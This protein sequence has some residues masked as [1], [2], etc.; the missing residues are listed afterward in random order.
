MT[1][2]WR[3]RKY[4]HYARTFPGDAALAYRKEGWRGVVRT[5]ADRSVR[6]CIRH[7]RL[8]VIA[9][10]LKESRE[11]SPPPGVTI[12]VARGDADWAALAAI[13]PAHQLEQFRAR[14]GPGRTCLAA[15]RDR[16]PIGY[17]WCAERVAPDILP[18]PVALPPDAAY[19]FDLYVV[20]AE[21]G[22]N[23]GSALAS[24]RMALARSR[25]CAEGWRLVAPENHASLRT[26]EKTGGSGTR[27]V[28]ELHYVKLGPR[29]FA[30]LH[31]PPAT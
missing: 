4:A 14:E 20:P 5:L 22:N 24:A 30:R 15:W 27:V 10:D 11:V 18:Y 17:T 13:V 16:Q 19:L 26:V 2:H 23:V 1:V 25:G 12:G 21:R 31:S 9:Q 7:G 29:I 6:Q 3:L 28:G 8:L